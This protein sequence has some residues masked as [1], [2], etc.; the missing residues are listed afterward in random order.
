MIKLNIIPLLEKVM[1][2]MN[3]P[4]SLPMLKL[5]ALLHVL[6]LGISHN[7]ILKVGILSSKDEKI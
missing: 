5:Y 4:P 3:L 7:L 1:I 2:R 6:T